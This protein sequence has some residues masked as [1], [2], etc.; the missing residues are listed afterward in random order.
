MIF[1]P[2]FIPEISQDY[3]SKLKSYQTANASIKDMKIL[4][5]QL[6]HTMMMRDIAFV[7]LQY[8]NDCAL[9]YDL[10]DLI[11]CCLQKSADPAS[12]DALHTY[13]ASQRFCRA[14]TSRSQTGQNHRI[15]LY[16]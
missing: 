7:K 12:A 11:L 15:S 14:G 5:L 6:G 4:I 10:R 8:V 1:L 9:G 16:I 3:H 2:I 13:L